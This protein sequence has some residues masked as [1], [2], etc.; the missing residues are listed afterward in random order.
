M[1][2]YHLRRRKK[3]YTF[4]FSFSPYKQTLMDDIK[5]ILCQHVLGSCHTEL[6]AI[7]ITL[8]GIA[9]NEYT[10]YIYLHR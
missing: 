3:N 2:H 10:T 7:A 4:L 9:I 8:V 1:K 5:D 6:F